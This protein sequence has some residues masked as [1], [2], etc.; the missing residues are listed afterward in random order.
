[1][2]CNY[3]PM[4]EKNNSVSSLNLN[5]QPKTSSLERPL[6]FGADKLL[7]VD[8]DLRR[9]ERGQSQVDPQVDPEPHPEEAL[10]AIS[11]EDA[12]Y[13]VGVLGLHEVR[14][15]DNVHCLSEAER[16]PKPTE[17][18]KNILRN[19]GNAQNQYILYNSR[20]QR[21]AR[22]SV[23]DVPRFHKWVRRLRLENFQ[24]FKQVWSGEAGCRVYTR[25]YR[26]LCWDFYSEEAAC[27]V[28]NSRMKNE[29]TKTTHLKYIY[30][31]LEGL[32]SPGEFYYFK[33]Q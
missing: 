2:W 30:R 19:F 5:L 18:T 33:K 24:Q 6:L 20:A 27:Y 15:G 28:L 4:L 29:L 25:L 16:K 26:E 8:E 32:V 23:A 9:V 17:D 13:L 14:Q 3:N 22:R 11:N 7:S 31:F 21:K 10:L 1:M 12:E